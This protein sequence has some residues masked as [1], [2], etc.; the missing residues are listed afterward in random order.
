MGSFSGVP[1]VELRSNLK[2]EFGSGMYSSSFSCYS[3]DLS[4]LFEFLSSDF[5]D[6]LGLPE[7]PTF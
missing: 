3:A 4:V 1:E 2:G 5:A 7:P 6:P